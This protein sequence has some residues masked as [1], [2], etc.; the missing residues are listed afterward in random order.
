[1]EPYLLK[2]REALF[3]EEFNKLA[4]LSDPPSSKTSTVAENDLEEDHNEASAAIEELSAN[5]SSA[6][7]MPGSA[8][9]IH[10]SGEQY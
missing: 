7:A 5:D 9:A 2:L 3:E 10:P 4:N 8:A 6:S 1:M